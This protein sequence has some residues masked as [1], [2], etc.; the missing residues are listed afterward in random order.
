MAQD[1][2]PTETMETALRLRGDGLTPAGLRLGLRGGDVLERINGLPFRGN[3]AA[4]QQR[5]A[6]AA[7]KPQALGFR[8]GAEE[9]LVLADRA[10]LGRWESIPCP[11][12]DTAAEVHRID[13]AGLQNYEVMRSGDGVYDIYPMKPSVMA[14]IA[15]PLWLLQM[16]L[17]VQ[18]ATLVA[19]LVAAAVV[20][21]WLAAA[22]WLAAGVWVRDSANAFLRMD[23]LGRG[24]GFAAVIAA[25]NEAE[26]HRKH[27][28]A[29]PGDRN[30]F[31]T[32]PRRAEQAA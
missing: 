21:P 16:R 8:R 31:A 29:Q 12:A 2:P 25:R 28:V 5:F 24:L 4:L 6:A 30:L 32:E 22:V 20:T 15:P 17:W 14:M 23:R 13:P 26:A 19:G 7:G 9:I 10:A 1:I 27:L 3:E 18:G 11:P